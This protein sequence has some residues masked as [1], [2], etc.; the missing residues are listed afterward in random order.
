MGRVG[1]P[2]EAARAVAFLAMDAASY[3]TGEH[4]VVDG[5]FSRLGVR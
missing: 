5:G 1:E 4:L 3:I 2:E